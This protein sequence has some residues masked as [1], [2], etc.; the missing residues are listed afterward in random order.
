MNP[1]GPSRLFHHTKSGRT[2]LTE[3]QVL[4]PLPDVPAR[5]MQLPILSCQLSLHLVL[6]VEGESFREVDFRTLHAFG[7]VPQLE[8]MSTVASRESHR[9]NSPYMPRSRR[10]TVVLPDSCQRTSSTC[11]HLSQSMT[12]TSGLTLALPFSPNGLIDR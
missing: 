10:R 7:L 4:G 11:Q 5:F 2:S 12:T 8:T 1:S 9:C 6:L 3:N